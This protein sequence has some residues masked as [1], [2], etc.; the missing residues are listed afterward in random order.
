MCSYELD[1]YTDKLCRLASIKLVLKKSRVSNHC[2]GGIVG[3][4]MAIH[5]FIILQLVFWQLIKLVLL[6]C[7]VN[8]L[9]YLQFV[10]ITC[11]KYKRKYFQIMNGETSMKR[12]FTFCCTKNLIFF[13]YLFF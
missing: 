1:G 4:H 11:V 2:I 10:Y 6:F 7:S 5:A 3:F 9:Q 13:V 12:H 8:T